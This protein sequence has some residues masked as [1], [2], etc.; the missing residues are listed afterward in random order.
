MVCRQPAS[1]ERGPDELVRLNGKSC[2]GQ[3]NHHR[4]LIYGFQIPAPKL[5]DHLKPKSDHRASQLRRQL[6][7]ILLILSIDVPYAANRFNGT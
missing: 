2:L 5:M 6:L 1:P 3:R 4:L 7:L